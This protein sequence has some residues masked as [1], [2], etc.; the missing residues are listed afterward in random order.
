MPWNECVDVQIN[1]G[2]CLLMFPGDLVDD[3]NVHVLS[4]GLA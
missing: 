2:L 3:Y 1:V 4:K